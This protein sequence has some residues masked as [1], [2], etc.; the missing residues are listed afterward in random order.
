MQRIKLSG[1]IIGI[2]AMMAVTLIFAGPASAANTYKTLHEF[3]WAQNPTG[4]LAQ[5]TAGNLYGTTQF[6]GGTGCGGSGCGVVWKLAQLP[7]GTWTAIILHV[8]TGTDGANPL[9][10]VT[11]D[12]SGN[13]YGT[14]SQG[15]G[16]S[17]LCYEYG[18]TGCGVVFKLSANADGSWTYRVIHNFGDSD[19]S[20]PAGSLIFDAAGNLFGTT[21]FGGSRTY[22]EPGCGVA[23]KLAPNSDGTWTESVLYAFGE[24]GTD[25]PAGM[26][27]DAS[28]NLYGTTSLWGP[29]PGTVFKLTPNSDGSWTETV[30]YNFGGLA[31]PTSGLVFDS[32]GNLY[33]TAQGNGFGVFKLAPNPDGTWTESSIHFAGAAFYP[34]GGVTFDAAGNLYGA[35]SVGPSG[36]GSVYKLTPT[37]SG[38]Q[39]SFA[40]V[41]WGYGKS[42]MSPILIDPSGHLYGTTSSGTG[43]SGL[44][45]EITP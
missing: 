43:N 6:G 30:L 24:L 45:F 7:S 25:P 22:C 5:D 2:L 8:F 21:Q 31:S 29:G 37:P 28:G 39:E 42:P 9:A 16:G 15:G 1:V 40:H 32:A 13:L 33:G 41:F 35:N 19:G 27:F 44:V 18:Q 38:W 20:N 11:L 12:P 4:V 34:A 23:Y 14:A 17:G 36:F 3:T 10:G 26:I